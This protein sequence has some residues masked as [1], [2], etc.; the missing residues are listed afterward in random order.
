MKKL[1]LVL[2][3]MLIP[4]MCY[5]KPANPLVK[6]DSVA[7]IEYYVDA[8]N[9]TEFD[10]GVIRIGMGTIDYTNGFRTMFMVDVDRENRTYMML[11]CIVVQPNGETTVVPSDGEKTKY[12]DNSIIYK[13][14]K[15]VMEHSGEKT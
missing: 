14:V 1:F 7:G 11:N 3:A 8:E 15:I 12:T 10:N 2:I 6:V 13:A 9:Y 4:V 5:A